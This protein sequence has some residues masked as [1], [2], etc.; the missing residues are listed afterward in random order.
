MKKGYAVVSALGTDR[1]GIVG[2]VTAVI[3]EHACNIEE[4][5]MISMGGEFAVIM[6]IDGSEQQ[7]DA[8]C[9]DTECWKGLEDLH[10]SLKRT[11][12]PRQEQT[13]GLPYTI[14]T[15]SQN[16]PGIVHAVTDLLRRRGLSILELETNVTPAPFTGSP[17]FAMKIELTASTV[18]EAEELRD[19]LHRIGQEENIDIHLSS[20]PSVSFD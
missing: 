10:V 20:H 2:D 14:K 4:S 16:T 5:R 19:E 6:L 12:P 13:A 8:L 18:S 1:V 3:K 17:M 11:R 15:L 9:D 7:I